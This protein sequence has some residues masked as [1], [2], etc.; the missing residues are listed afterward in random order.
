MFHHRRLQ[1]SEQE[2]FQHWLK[3]RPDQRLIELGIKT[4]GIKIAIL[5]LHDATLIM[6]Y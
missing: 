1:H 5:M 2:Q 3:T 6:K 4:L